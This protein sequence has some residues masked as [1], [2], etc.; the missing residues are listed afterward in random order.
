MTPVAAAAKR[1]PEQHY[2]HH[3]ARGAT[4][5]RTNPVFIHRE[6]TALDVV[7]GMNVAEI[8]TGSG[9]SGG[10]L[11]ELVGPTG[12]VTSLDIDPYLTRWANH[13]HAERGVNNVR[14]YAV[15]GTADYPGQ[16]PYHRMVGWCSPPL[17]PKAWVDQTTEDGLIVATLPVAPVPNLAAGAVIRV[18]GGQPYVESVFPGSDIETGSSP[19][20]DFS[21]PA[22]WV[23]W[24]SRIPATSWVSIAWREQDDWKSS[25]ARGVLERLREPG[26]TEQ[27]KGEE[28][29]WSSLRVWLAA[30]GARLT[31]TE[32]KPDVIGL[33]HSTRNTAA[34]IQQDGTVIADATDSASLT[35]LRGWL[36]AWEYVDRPGPDAYT[37]NLVP[38][39]DGDIPGWDLRLVR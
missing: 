24:E 25:G 13:I 15:D 16:A 3:E 6:L 23:D 35:V 9:L 26:H 17:L 20:S 5:H 2:T 7:P 14:C 30:T 21:V 39:M 38:D 34:V 8:G 37:A 32:L 22:R 18:R 28:I 1:V 27:Y 36:A 31:M 33:G 12:M 4:I 11:A 10:L 29:D 19:R